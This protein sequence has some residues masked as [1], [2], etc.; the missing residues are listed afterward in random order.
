MKIFFGKTRSEGRLGFGP[1]FHDLYIA[2]G[3]FQIIGGAADDGLPQAV[4]RAVAGFKPGADKTGG[5]LL[6]PTVIMDADV[7]EAIGAE[8]KGAETGAVCSGF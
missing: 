3:I 8:R 6:G 2:A 1:H 4:D 7:Q 5:L